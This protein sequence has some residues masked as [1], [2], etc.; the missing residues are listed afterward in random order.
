MPS[1]Y[2]HRHRHTGVAELPLHGG[3]APRWLFH[4]MASLGRGIM[5]VLLD[6]YGSQEILRRIADPYWFQALSCVLGYDWH[7]SGTTTVTCAAL[8]EAFQPIE[9][10]VA[11]AGGKGTASRKTPE[12]LQSL[13]S[14]FHWSEQEIATLTTA[15]RMS[16]KVDTTAIQA[17]YP[18]YH[19]AFFVDHK[20]NWV[21]IQQGINTEDRTAR[22]YHWLS[23]HVNSFIQEP[24]DA[25]VGSPVKEA[26]LDMTARE[27]ERSQQIAVDLVNDNPSHLHHTITALQLHDQTTLHRWIDRE[28]LPA[29]PRLHTFA[30]PKRM[31]WAALR[32]AYEVHPQNYEEF[33][34]LPGIGPATVRGLALVSELIY[35]EAPSWRDPVKYSF[36]YGGKDGVPFPVDRHAMDASIQFLHDALSQVKGHDRTK[37]HAFKRLRSLNR[38]T[39][40]PAAST[41]RVR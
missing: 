39:M 37:L 5:D 28:D 17:G 21:V 12:E 25:I 9:H 7:S 41:L 30:M 15:S 8:K 36:A 16:T 27:S 2:R 10:G 38:D 34:G 33:L 1:L 19:H 14:V 3:R 22:R 26:V 23:S 20:A 35:G 11:V 18:L 31:N 6:E 32:H 40:N 29:H 13:G 4:R 24:H